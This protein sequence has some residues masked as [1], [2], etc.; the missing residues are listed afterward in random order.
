M[1]T[2][3]L[4]LA[5]AVAPA[6]SGPVTLKWSLKEGDLFYAKTVQ[7]MDMSLGVL[8][9]NQDIKQKMTTVLRFKVKSA[10]AGA[11]VVEMTYVEFSADG[12]GIPGIAGI[13]EKLKGATITATLND[14]LKVTKVDGYD[15]FIDSLSGGDENQKAMLKVIMSEATVQQMFS[16]TFAVAPGKPVA[17]GDTWTDSDKLSMGPLGDFGLKQMF[18]LESVTD[19]VAKISSKVE[20]DFKPGGGGGALPFK[21]T[22]ADLKADKFG[23]IYSFDIK[24]GRLKEAVVDG[25]IGGSMTASAN[26]QDIEITMKIKTKGTTTVTDKNP[27]R[28]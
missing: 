18:K 11:T 12:G 16:Q 23:G 14:K 17:V 5:L 4:A 10:S 20:M 19:G 7:D 26:G 6:Q 28:D 2:A 25:S 21:I 13:G 8:G 24:S 27:V 1:L 22:K 9:M 15:K 3:T